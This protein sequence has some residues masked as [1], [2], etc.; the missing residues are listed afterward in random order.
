MAYRI[1]SFR[2]FSSSLSLGHESKDSSRMSIRE[3][4]SP[5]LFPRATMSC[6]LVCQT[7][8][9]DSKLKADFIIGNNGRQDG[10]EGA[11]SRLG[12]PILRNGGT[13]NTL[14]VVPLSLHYKR[15]STRKGCCWVTDTHEGLLFVAR[16]PYPGH[17]V[18]VDADLPIPFLWGRDQER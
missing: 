10:F 3:R 13:L 7:R 6:R 4:R 9:F 16:W 5:A 8:V 17:C 12:R 2:R 18:P 1:T 14:V 15:K 11:K